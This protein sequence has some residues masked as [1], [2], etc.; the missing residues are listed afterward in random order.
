MRKFCGLTVL[1]MVVF[2]LAAPLALAREDGKRGPRQ[3]RAERMAKARAMRLLG[4]PILVLEK[5]RAEMKRHQT[6]LQGFDKSVKELQEKVKKE[7]EGGT[8]P[9]EALKNHLDDAKVLA[10]EVIGE[11]V[12]HFGNM[13]TIAKDEGEILVNRLARQL[14][15]PR[16]APGPPGKRPPRPEG[17]G[18][19]GPQGGNP[20]NE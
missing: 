15:L 8:A 17:K 16:K 19:Q 6:A 9:K 2:A 5:A 4:M 3:D 14:L 20:F 11:C 13:A 10:K 12:T 7:I 18:K 1:C